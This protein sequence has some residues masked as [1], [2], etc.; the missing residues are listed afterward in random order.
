MALTKTPIELSSTPSIVDGGN[1]TA[2]TIDS[3]EKVGI[4]NSSP[5]SYFS[6]A[7][8]LVVGGTTGANG[9]TISGSTDTQIFFADGTSGADA[10]RGIIRYSHAD[11]GFSL[12]T[13]G[14]RRLDIDSSGN[15]IVGSTNPAP[16]S[17]NVVGV[18]IRNFGEVQM[19][20]NNQ[21]PLYLNR[22]GTDGPLVTLRKENVDIGTIGVSGGTPYISAA[23]G[24]G[25][26]FTYYN[27][28]NAVMFP[29]TTTG[30]N[31]DAVHDIGHP[32]VRFKDLYLSGG[33]NFSANA[34]AAGA[35]SELLDDYEEG[36]W[37]P[38]LIGCDAVTF[39]GAGLY[40]KIGAL[41][42]V[43]WYSSAF[44]VSNAVG[45]NA[46]I[47]GLP[48]AGKSG[49]YGS[50][51][52]A[53]TTAFTN[54]AAQGFTNSTATEVYVSFEGGTSGNTWSQ[55]FPKYVMMSCIYFTDS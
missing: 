43:Q 18:S 33:V 29:V 42:H 49:K 53:H 38:T 55:G 15:F 48:F 28:T 12:W 45:G 10:Y 23:T 47:G 17:N 44:T 40:V 24:G 1:A 8:N 9:M 51:S 7:N 4:F 54:S 37:T 5:S 14:T 25:M 36:T 11:N 6:N 46:R 35:S 13:D 3:S 19:S 34:N 20:T 27:S 16:V 31:A 22:K 41:V 50:A 39:S 30:A 32:S 26:K 21:G 2:I 52:F